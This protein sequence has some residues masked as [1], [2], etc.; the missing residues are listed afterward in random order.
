MKF[1][2]SSVLKIGLRI[3]SNTSELWSVGY[4]RRVSYDV[5]TLLVTVVLFHHRIAFDCRVVVVRWNEGWDS[6]VDRSIRHNWILIIFSRYLWQ[7]LD[8]FWIPPNTTTMKLALSFALL[9]L[10]Y[11]FAPRT[12][13]RTSTHLA[14]NLNGWVP[15]SKAF[16]YGLP[17][18]LAPVGEFDPLGFAKDANL[19]TIKR[20]REAEVQ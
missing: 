20:Y 2:T 10:A 4:H 19:D 6:I 16:C 12:S 15:D 7:R 18:A 5:P 14:G 1:L 3:E 11:G 17:G 8:N 9:S 13:P